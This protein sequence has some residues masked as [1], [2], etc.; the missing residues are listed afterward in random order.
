VFYGNEEGLLNKVKGFKKIVV[1]IHNVGR[2]AASNFGFN[3]ASLSVINA[4]QEKDNCLSFMFGNA[5]A[6]KN[7]CAAKNMVLCYEDDNV[8]QGAAADLLQGKIF[9]KGVLPVSVCDKL[10]Y[11]FGIETKAV[12]SIFEKANSD[13]L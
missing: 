1:G 8:V 4:L 10:K 13:D 5:Y 2:Y 6:L 7:M 3:A 11:G 9:Y 12:A